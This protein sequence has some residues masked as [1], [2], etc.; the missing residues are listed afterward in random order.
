MLFVFEQPGRF[1]FWMFEMQF[2]L[3]LVWISAGCAV[4]DLTQNAPPP[5]PGQSPGDLPRYQPAEPVQ[6]V[7]EV[8]A[9][10]IESAGIA[11]GDPVAF[12]GDLAGVYGC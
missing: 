3:D 7:L 12:E 2:P 6:Y 1:T 9:G 11:V 4:V 8:N 5:Q 10:V